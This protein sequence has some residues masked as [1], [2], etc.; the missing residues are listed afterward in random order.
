MNPKSHYNTLTDYALR[1]RS[2]RYLLC[3]LG[4]LLTFAFVGCGREPTSADETTATK[5]QPE[6]TPGR[7]ATET[8]AEPATESEADP[9][10]AQPPAIVLTPPVDAIPYYASDSS[11]M[12]MGRVTD[13]AAAESAENVEWLTFEVVG[14]PSAR[15]NIPF[16][17]ADGQFIFSLKTQDFKGLHA[18]RLTAVSTA[19]I[20]GVTEIMLFDGNEKPSLTTVRPQSYEIT[21]HESESAAR[22]AAGAGAAI[23]PPPDVREAAQ[24]DGTRTAPAPPTTIPRPGEV[25]LS[26]LIPGSNSGIPERRPPPQRVLKRIIIRRAAPGSRVEKEPGPIP[27]QVAI[28]SP[29]NMS[30][31]G[32]SVIVA[33][34]VGNSQQDPDSTSEIERLSY[35]LEIDPPIASNIDFDSRT[36]T[37]DF[38]LSSGNYTGQ[39]L[40]EI[41]ATNRNNQQAS[42]RLRLLFTG[43]GPAIAITAPSDEAFYRSQVSVIGRVGNSEEDPESAGQVASL[44]YRSGNLSADP[45]EIDFH[46]SNGTFSFDFDTQ[47]V[48]GKLYLFITAQDRIGGTRHRLLTL[49]D[50]KLSPILEISTPQDGSAYGAGVY[51]TGRLSLS[52]GEDPLRE[53]I[54]S[55]T[56]EIASAETFDVHAEA[57]SGEIELDESGSFR[58]LLTTRELT[59]S[60]TITVSAEALNGN[61]HQVSVT[62]QRGSSD[63]P[64]FRVAPADG[65]A[66]LDWDPVPLA[67]SYT[68]HYSRSASSRPEA[69][70]ERL[71]DVRPPLVLEDLENGRVYAFKLQAV[72]PA[73]QEASWSDV[74]TA[75]P[76]SPLTLAPKVTGEYGQIRVSWPDIAATDEYVVLRATSREG[77]FAEL[78]PAPSRGTYLDRDVVYGR[79]YYY[80]I[81]PAAPGSVVS[82]SRAGKTTAFPARRLKQVASLSGASVRGVFL[83]ADYAYLACGEHGLRIVD[84]HDPT[85]PRLVGSLDTSEAH[86][87]TVRDDYLYLADGER[88]IAIIDVSDPLNPE[89]IGSR[90]TSDA[91]DL[92]LRGDFAYVAD[93]IKGFKVLDI[94]N[95]RKP[96][97]IATVATQQALAVALAGDYAVLA[98]AEAGLKII[99]ISNPRR[100][101]I[102]ASYETPFAVGITIKG[103]RAYVADK[104]KGLI[105]LDISRPEQPREIWTSPT[106]GARHVY[107]NGGYAF[108]ADGTAGLKVLDIS[109]ADNPTLFGSIRTSNAAS[110]FV[111]G[112]HAYIADA[113]GLL[114]VQAMLV[115][116][117][118]Q[119]AEC[120]VDGRATRITIEGPYAYIASHEGGVKVVDIADPAAVGTHSIA[121]A[122]DTE[123]AGDIAVRESLA[124]VAD[125]KNGLLLLDVAPAWDRDPNSQPSILGSFAVEGKALAV[126]I[127]GNLV[128]VAG[129]KAGVEVVDVSN[130]KL[131]TLAGRL[132][133]SDAR[134]IALVTTASGNLYACVADYIEGLSIVDL[135]DPARPRQIAV[136][137]VR[138]ARRL[139][140][141]RTA[142]GRLYALVAGSSGMTIIDITVPE[143]PET[144]GAFDT[145]F[146]EALAVSG[147]HVLL[148]DGYRGLKVID[149]SL[150]SAPI[151]VSEYDQT[152]VVGVAA[153]QTASAGAFAFVVDSAGLRVIEILIP[154]WLR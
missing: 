82:A 129:G 64:S 43:S 107:L 90:K 105:A 16:Y 9:E 153:G 47:Q 44:V 20:P 40:L 8:L 62:L 151:L 41:T 119:I 139:T 29:Q 10:P 3:A 32:S 127:S 50:G 91:C 80:R 111:R 132:Q 51:V 58:F 137:E 35:R 142:E 59:G 144:V 60:Q 18:L 36:G 61:R 152:Y 112:H 25:A 134:D 4:L 136:Q 7:E 84:I 65:K 27:P 93:G 113:A 78:G 57:M 66:M 99:D 150:P 124:A 23:T 81:K 98:D 37:F 63:I 21:A 72:S 86:A 14:I 83:R 108:V 95:P 87:L 102:K 125:G 126:D 71:A 77:N 53:A 49:R 145:G 138:G 115:G 101:V 6:S 146:A 22:A 38:T 116:K 96:A 131:P 11:V 148:A 117:S 42:R 46:P 92:A 104:K 120:A 73:G 69:D 67:T 121:G 122:C 48:N 75:I 12:V 133:S 149:I 52:A 24:S 19:G 26:R 56:Y 140:I 141:H 28:R 1:A 109:D 68:L 103:S 74:R 31:W 54:K 135:S 39:A 118:L 79:T 85:E 89:K 128:A 15:G 110:V 154:D 30:S 100:P 147:N 143:A 130:P 45:Q 55:L 34:T 13:S 76:L 97:R 106:L 2:A 17:N 70:G 33:G 123:Y 114:I 5:E 94:S 88:G